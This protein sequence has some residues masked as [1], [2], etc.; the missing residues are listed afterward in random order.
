LA[1]PLQQ[2]QPV[3]VMVV[4]DQLG[5]LVAEAA[6]VIKVLEIEILRSRKVVEGG[7]RDGGDAADC[8]GGDGYY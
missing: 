3:L 8:G 7:E 2:S 1:L 4:V 5:L 6:V